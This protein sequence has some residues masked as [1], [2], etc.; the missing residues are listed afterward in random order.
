MQSRW[1]RDSKLVTTCCR[2]NPRR[3]EM[4]VTTLIEFPVLLIS[5]ILRVPCTGPDD[6]YVTNRTS[7]GVHALADCRLTPAGLVRAALENASEG[8]TSQWNE[9]LT[10]AIEADADFAPARWQAGYVRDGDR[11]LTIEE[12]MSAARK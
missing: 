2:A 6:S 9:Y 3:I 1:C 11:W 4:Q 5:T 10:K 12:A 7:A 8:N